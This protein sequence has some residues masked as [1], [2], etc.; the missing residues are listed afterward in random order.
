MIIERTCVKTT[1]QIMYSGFILYYFLQCINMS[2]QKIFSVS[3]ILSLTKKMALTKSYF[4]S[5]SLKLIISIYITKK[6][7]TKSNH[8]LPI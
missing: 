8:N 2:V 1:W 6:Q 3:N 7:E 5:R 4:W